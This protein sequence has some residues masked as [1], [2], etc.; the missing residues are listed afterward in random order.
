MIKDTVHISVAYG[1]ITPTSLGTTKTKVQP[2]KISDQQQNG[3]LNQQNHQSIE[4]VEGRSLPQNA[5]Q[6]HNFRF[7]GTQR[8]MASKKTFDFCS[9]ESRV[10]MEWNPYE[11]MEKKCCK[12]YPEEGL[13][14]TYLSPIGL[15]ANWQQLLQSFLHSSSFFQFLDSLYRSFTVIC[16][17]ERY[18]HRGSLSHSFHMLPA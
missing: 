16:L 6:R 2:I 4:G 8:L 14:K 15:R 11:A 12:Y 17:L 9:A 7:T 10:G 3:W 1:S 18:K 13:S 5:L